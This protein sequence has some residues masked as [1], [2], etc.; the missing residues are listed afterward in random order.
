MFLLNFFLRE[1]KKGL[2]IILHAF[3][4]CC[5][6][7]CGLINN[8]GRI[9]CKHAS[10][11]EIDQ[12]HDCARVELEPENLRSGVKTNNPGR[13]GSVS[14]FLLLYREDAPC[15]TRDECD[16]HR[17][18]WRRH[19]DSKKLWRRHPD[20]KGRNHVGEGVS[21]P[22][23]YAKKLCAAVDAL[24]TKTDSGTVRAQEASHLVWCGVN[25]AETANKN[26]GILLP[27]FDNS[28]A[29]GFQKTKRNDRT[30][31][32]LRVPSG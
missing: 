14:D 11:I 18:L 6:R 25:A 28:A 29:K 22:P 31:V 16:T 2:K 12:M 3:T 19:P 8:H 32:N 27:G 30:H 17:K 5:R 1:K 4:R 7:W 21:I 9:P 10:A 24:A 20:S 13:V 23:N 15:T 26:C